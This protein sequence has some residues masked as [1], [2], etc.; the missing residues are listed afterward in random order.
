MRSRI[1]V[2]RFAKWAC[3]GLCIFMAVGILPNPWYLAAFNPEATSAYYF[4]NGSI[5]VFWYPRDQDV[6][7]LDRTGVFID[8]VGT[9]SDAT[10]LWAKRAGWP[11]GRSNEKSG[12]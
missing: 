9:M 12:Y 6:P 1:R 2:R 3:I 8:R 4:G 7:S 5:A 11:K 10:M